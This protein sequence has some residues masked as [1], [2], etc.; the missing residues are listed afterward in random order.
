MLSIK[1]HVLSVFWCSESFHFYKRAHIESGYLS[2]L[3]K[4]IKSYIIVILRLWLCHLLQFM[5]AQVLLHVKPDDI[6]VCGIVHE[7]K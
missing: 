1:S 3:S 7:S 5:L 2:R 6:I 4:R